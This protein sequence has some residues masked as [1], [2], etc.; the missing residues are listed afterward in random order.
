MALAIVIMIIGVGVAA[1]LDMGPQNLEPIITHGESLAISNFDNH[2]IKVDF[3][4]FG[5]STSYSDCRFRISIGTYDSSAMDIL[6]WQSIYISSQQG[7]T[8]DAFFVD[9]DDNGIIDGADYCV[10]STQNVPE[11]LQCSI[12]I[13][14]ANTGSTMANANF[15]F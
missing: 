13:L 3:I 11:G 10:L 14:N 4:N 8:I 6:T 15:A 12:A 2:T 7:L 9:V 1:L 5:S